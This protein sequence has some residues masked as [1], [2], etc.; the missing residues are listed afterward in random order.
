MSLVSFVV[1]LRLA[2]SSRYACRPVVSIWRFRRQLHARRHSCSMRQG[3]IVRD[4]QRRTSIALQ[5][6]SYTPPGVHMIVAGALVSSVSLVVWYAPPAYQ[7]ASVRS[8]C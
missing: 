5:P 6:V 2:Y 8:D 3:K 1:W 7:L 4:T